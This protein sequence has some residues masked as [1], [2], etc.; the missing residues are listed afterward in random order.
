MMGVSG[1]VQGSGT[2]TGY[3]LFARIVHRRRHVLVEHA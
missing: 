1:F 3:P 2:G